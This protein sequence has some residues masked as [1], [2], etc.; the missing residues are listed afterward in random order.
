MGARKAMSPARHKAELEVFQGLWKGGYFEGDPLDPMAPSGYGP[1]GYIS[2]LH[3]TY[4][5]CIRPY[6]DERTRVLEI[7]PGR[8][9][10][11]KC[12]VERNAKQIWAL[13]ALSAE[14]NGFWE[15]VGHKPTVRYFQVEDSL[16][17]G[18]PDASIDYVF[19][20]GTLCHLSPQVIND[21]M[22]SVFIKMRPG[23]VGFVM[24]ADYT[25]WNSMLASEAKFSISRS[26]IGKR[27]LPIR[28]LWR[29]LYSFVKPH[30]FSYWA[31]NEDDTPRP[32]RWYDLGTA[33]A[34][35][36]LRAIGFTV[37]DPDVGV[38]H[39]DPIIHFEKPSA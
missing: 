29:S 26:F 23:A 12:F 39:R 6:V 20:F 18:V 15:Y 32:G 3:V 33:T 25:K 28:L 7:G 9:A 27:L 34:V 8:G 30:R 35:E 38:N 24:I 37:I 11:T 1:F 21:Y 17:T 13:D 10:W 5:L 2:C 36:M 14:H 4:L 22:K 16:C 19:S 31:E